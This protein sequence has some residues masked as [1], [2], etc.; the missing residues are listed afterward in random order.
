MTPMLAL[1][2]IYENGVV[3][4]EKPL[5][6][7]RRMKVIVT[8]LE[9]EDEAKPL[10]PEDFSFAKTRKTTSKYNFSLSEAVIEERREAL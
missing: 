7:D 9:E 2:G 8:F 4:L 10:S 5:N 3:K 1:K 6:S